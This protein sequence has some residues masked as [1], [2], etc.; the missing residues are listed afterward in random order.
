[1]SALL[2]EPVL[3]LVWVDVDELFVLVFSALAVRWDFNSAERV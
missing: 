3:G 2:C 1:M